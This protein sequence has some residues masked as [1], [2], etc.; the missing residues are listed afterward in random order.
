M[1]F[2]RILVCALAAVV[3]TGLFTGCS[4]KT[5]LNDRNK[6]LTV[7]ARDFIETSHTVHPNAYMTENYTALALDKSINTNAGYVAR[8]IDYRLA[9]GAYRFSA[10]ARVSI[11]N[12]TDPVLQ[13][14]AVK[15]GKAVAN[16][17]IMG[18]K[19]KSI[20]TDY[21]IEFETEDAFVSFG[22]YSNGR[23][24]VRMKNITV[25]KIAK[26][27][28]GTLLAEYLSED[29]ADKNL[30]LEDGKVYFYDL[31]E[32]LE[33][34]GDYSYQEQLMTLAASL[35]GLA[36]REKPR[37]FIRFI[38]DDDSN[39]VLGRQ[40]EN[41]LEYLQSKNFL[42]TGADL[43]RIQSLGTLLRLFR[44][45]YEGLT[46]WDVFSPATYNVGLTDCGVNN[47]LLVKYSDE[48]NSAYKYLTEVLKLPVKLDLHDK[49]PGTRG[50]KIW[51][52]DIDST[53]SKKSDPYYYAAEKYIKTKKVNPHVMSSYLDGWIGD[54]GVTQRVYY[55]ENG[56]LCVGSGGV[57]YWENRFFHTD[58]MNR[59][60]FVAQKAFF[61]DLSPVDDERP[62]DD[63]KQTI[64]RD[65]D[66][67]EYI[68]RENNKNAGTKIVEVGG[69]TN[70]QLKYSDASADN[71]MAG[72]GLE[73]AM[74]RIL[75]KYNATMQAD[76]HSI[77]A[78]ANGSVYMRYP[79]KT[80]YNQ[81]AAR[82]KMLAKANA[83]TLG[84]K[85]YLLF[86][87][88]DYDGAAWV[89]REMYSMFNDPNLGKIPLMWPILP[90]NEG[91]VGHV[92]D[93]IYEHATENDIFVGGN[94]GYGYNYLDVFLTWERDGLN[95]T[96]ETYIDQT[97]TVYKKYDLDIMGMYFGGW[98][99]ASTAAQNTWRTL[100]AQLSRLSP[101]GVVTSR[102]RRADAL[103]DYYNAQ[104][105]TV[106]VCKDPFI[107]GRDPVVQ[108]GNGMVLTEGDSLHQTS[109]MSQSINVTRE[110]RPHFNVLRPVL[111]TPTQ[112]Y[113]AVNT[114]NKRYPEYNFE[115]VDPYTFFKL[116]KE[117]LDN[118]VAGDYN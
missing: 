23:N 38:D 111:A 67:L 85:N 46:A 65:T 116:Y 42:P 72:G 34:I 20:Y 118:V 57:P 100:Y 54:N 31:R 17:N 7:Q 98:D 39:A 86:Y 99:A 110:G 113:E 11:G 29:A 25:E 59:D 83:A 104:T 108:C 91:R 4:R 84:N 61:F 92:Y 44:P 89:N 33:A 32:K 102:G 53:G 45:F 21:A 96:L 71:A 6:T 28:D 52:T 12:E 79:A 63:E 16:L 60:Y 76:A 114:L 69:F 80:Q 70:W 87:M 103:E 24:D 10:Q 58:I 78:M 88:G 37:M 97:V 36:N 2:K 22:L 66:T 62:V 101:Y 14:H 8:T 106:F 13:L 1:K 82:Q 55:D 105:G 5:D 90:I 107:P 35:Q 27:A 112:A 117:Y 64:G 9:K 30:A 47:R 73:P 68:L 43:I 19:S 48:I 51:D 93:Y 3:G 40:D 18:P 56:Q 49:F 115:A 50:K 109:I 81:D 15:G 95:G 41:W 75:T 77:S 74:V 94:N 26:N